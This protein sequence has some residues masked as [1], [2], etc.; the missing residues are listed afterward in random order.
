MMCVNPEQEALI[1]ACGYAGLRVG[2]ALAFKT[3]WLDTHDMVIT[4]R[5]K[6]D[7]ERIVPCSDRAWSAISRAYIL[8][9]QGDGRLIHM[10]DRTARHTVTYLGRQARISREISSHDLRA[11]Y[12]TIMSDQGVNIRVIQ[13]LLGHSSVTS[14]EIYTGVNLAAMRDAVQF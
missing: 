4:V 12:A 3:D 7:K 2:E 11:T 13:E 1:G 5:G 10:P 6:G 9:M 8:A 14:T